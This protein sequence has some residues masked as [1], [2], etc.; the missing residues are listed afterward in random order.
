MALSRRLATCLL[1]GFFVLSACSDSPSV[2]S[3]PGELLVTLES[4]H[5]SEGA[6]VLEVTG[7]SFASARLLHSHE[8][9][10]FTEHLTP[11][12]ALVAVILDAPGEVR[13]LITL[14]DLGAPPSVGVHSVSDG[15]DRLRSSTAGYQVK[16][17]SPEEGP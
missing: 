6:A 7:G 13:F 10:L 11:E 14:D 15:Q 16:L 8:G 2:P 17:T 1:A 4:P 5:G 12:E 9:L 3:G